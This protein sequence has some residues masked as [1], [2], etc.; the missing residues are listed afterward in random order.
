MKLKYNKTTIRKS[1]YL[2]KICTAVIDTCLSFIFP[3]IR[4]SVLSVRLIKSKKTNK[5]N[6]AIFY[7]F[8]VNN[9]NTRKRY[10]C[11]KLTIKTPERRQWCQWRLLVLLL[12]LKISHIL[13]WGFY[14]WLWTSKCLL[15]SHFILSSWHLLVQNQQ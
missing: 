10:I 5:I 6:P 3:T 13:F 12:T 1:P 14:C 4:I 15:G 7:L 9:R 2:L 8:N 11:S